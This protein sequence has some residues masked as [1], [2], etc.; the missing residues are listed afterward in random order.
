MT[1]YFHY[2]QLP[3][4]HEKNIT[5][6]LQDVLRSWMSDHAAPPYGH[7][8]PPTQCSHS[9]LFLCHSLRLTQT[10]PETA[11]KMDIRILAAAFPRI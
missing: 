4:Q 8:T 2:D 7:T 10:G 9:T 5:S 6:L 11:K 3:G 1:G